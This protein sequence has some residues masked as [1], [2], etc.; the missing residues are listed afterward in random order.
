MENTKITPVLQGL[1]LSEHEAGVYYANLALGPAT[2]L[3][4]ARR[5]NIK[6]TTVYSVLDS[7]RN[8]GL[9]SVELKGL[10]QLYVASPPQV[11]EGLLESR[12]SAFKGVLPELEKLY[13]QRGKETTIRYHEGLVSVKSAYEELL[14]LTRQTDD[15]LV[16]SNMERWLAQDEKY[17]K[18]F[19]IRC[20]QRT[21]KVR[22]IL[23]NSPKALEYK[24]L[25]QHNRQRIRILSEGTSLTTNLVVIPSRVVIQQMIEPIS[26]IVIDNPSA[27]QM[28]REM[29]EIMWNAL[30]E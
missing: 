16:V 10:K 18:E 23:Q 30:S 29:F 15:Y 22:V 2:V 26:A 19:V 12:R 7:L 1:G 14:G 27:V 8:K 25:Q 11:L 21:D 9:I 13:N 6:R 24:A 5:A 28:H 20:A 4:I 3:R 17:F